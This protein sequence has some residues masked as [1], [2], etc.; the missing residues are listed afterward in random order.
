MG[1]AAFRK[2]ISQSKSGNKVVWCSLKNK[3]PY[4]LAF[5]VITLSHP[6]T[7]SLSLLLARLVWVHL[8]CGIA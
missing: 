7:I 5:Y 3:N 8:E 6:L 2:A 4:L 1:S